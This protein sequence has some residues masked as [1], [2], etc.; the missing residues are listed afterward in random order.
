MLIHI[1]YVYTL[2]LPSLLQLLQLL[3]VLDWHTRCR[4]IPDWWWSV[5]SMCCHSVQLWCQQHRYSLDESFA[6]RHG[7]YTSV[8]HRSWC[9]SSAA[10][11]PHR[12]HSGGG[13]GG[14]FS[15]MII[16]LFCQAVIVCRL[17][18]PVELSFNS[19][20]FWRKL[21]I[22]KTYFCIDNFE[23]ILIYRC[24]VA[25][26]A[27]PVRHELPLGQ[28]KNILLHASRVRMPCVWQSGMLLRHH[29]K[30]RH[31]L[32]SGVYCKLHA[33]GTCSQL[34]TIILCQKSAYKYVCVTALIQCFAQNAWFQQIS[35]IFNVLM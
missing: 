15:K 23:N 10:W 4:W 2:L 9:C 12:R 3:L 27:D 24:Q 30:L 14:T 35:W 6:V 1:R 28:R 16:L 29:I 18:F 32:F 11:P 17:R 22:S 7:M 8:T 31:L 13:G 21:Q 33:T 34:L 26:I 19:L 20:K 25:V 5:S